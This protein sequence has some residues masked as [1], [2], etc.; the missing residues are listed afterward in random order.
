MS[1]KATDL[2]RVQE[3]FDLIMETQGQVEGCRRYCDDHGLELE[4]G[5]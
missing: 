4:A 3:I 2:A 1:A 5:R